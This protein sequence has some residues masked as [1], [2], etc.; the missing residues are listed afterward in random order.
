[1]SKPTKTG[2]PTIARELAELRRSGAAGLHRNRRPRST[3]RR[4]ALAEQ[5]VRVSVR[6]VFA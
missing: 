1:M 3:E 4:Q 5:D 6:R 2:T